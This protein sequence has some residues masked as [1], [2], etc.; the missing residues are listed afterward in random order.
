M[1]LH[2]I[3]CHAKI[4]LSMQSV[5]EAVDK[6]LTELSQGSPSWRVSLITFADEVGFYWVA[7]QSWVGERTNFMHSYI[8]ALDMK[9]LKWEN[10]S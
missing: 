4:Y 8:F 5:Q 10:V 2:K 1:Y 3:L 9:Y 7:A 6:Q